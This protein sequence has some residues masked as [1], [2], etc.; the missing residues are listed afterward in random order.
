MGTPQGNCVYLCHNAAPKL[1]VANRR[2]CG[3]RTASPSSGGSA[4]TFRR[5]TSCAIGLGCLTWT[6]QLWTRLMRR[7]WT[8][9]CRVLQSHGYLA[10]P[11]SPTWLCLALTLS[12]RRHSQRVCCSLEWHSFAAD[13]EPVAVTCRVCHLP[14]K[15]NAVVCEECTLICHARCATEAPA[16]C[17]VRTKLLLFAHYANPG[18]AN[19]ADLHAPA[20]PLPTATPTRGLMPPSSPPPNGVYDSTTKDKHSMIPWRRKSSTPVAPE[21]IAGPS[22][23]PTVNRR[24]KASD[25]ISKSRASLSLT[26]SSQQSSLRSAV[27]ANDT[28]SSRANEN[29]VRQL[30]ESIPE[31]QSVTIVEPDTRSSRLTQASG[32]TESTDETGFRRR[33][34]S[35]ESTSS[36]T[37]S[38]NGCTIQ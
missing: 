19:S 26:N 1:I 25:D 27:T 6:S 29:G 28:M 14:I 7:S 38:K 20:S 31:R 21:Q 13:C 8:V 2:N 37:S 15:K 17:D 12:S 18:A 34:K 35:R 23:S 22:T 11:S 33:H 36:R 10:H 5:R 16:T 30:I 24:S 32:Q 3:R 9:I 4:R